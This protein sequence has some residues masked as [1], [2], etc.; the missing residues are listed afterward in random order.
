VKA[1]GNATFR[2]V[3][4]K[5]PKV[6]VTSEKVLK[7]TAV[8]IND[9]SVAS[10]VFQS[11]GGPESVGAPGDTNV[12]GVYLFGKEMADLKRVNFFA[13]D[14][15]IQSKTIRLEDV[16]FRQGSRVLLE[17]AI[18][19]LADNPN[20]NAPVQPGKVNFVRNV[21]YGSS[22]AEN[23]V[24]QNGPAPTPSGPGIVIRPFKGRP[25]N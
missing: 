13:N 5:A 6:R 24:I 2:G 15:L 18:G 7:M 17:S 19:V 11:E 22:P 25:S 8:Q 16:R 20:Q 1:L 3:A 4:L 23:A 10:V 12:S 21:Q 9:G 14:V